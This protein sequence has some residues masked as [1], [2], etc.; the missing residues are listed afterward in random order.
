MPGQ[1]QLRRLPGLREGAG[2]ASALSKQTADDQMRGPQAA[3]DSQ[4][5]VTMGSIRRKNA[6]IRALNHRISTA[7]AAHSYIWMLPY[8]LSLAT[9]EPW[10]GTRVEQ[11]A[12]G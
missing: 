3:F 6:K 12:K 1:A 11:G 7:T 5:A 10:G 8:W 9:P 2:R 4:A